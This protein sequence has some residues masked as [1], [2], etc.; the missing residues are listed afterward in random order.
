MT[1]SIVSIGQYRTASKQLTSDYETV[2]VYKRGC[3]G[4]FSAVCCKFHFESQDDLLKNYFK[5]QGP[6][7]YDKSSFKRKQT[8]TQEQQFQNLVKEIKWQK[9]VYYQSHYKM[10]ASIRFTGMDS[11]RLKTLKLHKQNI[12]RTY[13]ASQFRSTADNT[14]TEISTRSPQL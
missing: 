11:E 5:K 4:N 13:R 8:L 12:E 10:E 14:N 6:P 9:E 7:C 3:A 1:K 2:L